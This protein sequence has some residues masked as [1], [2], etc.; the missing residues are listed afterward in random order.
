MGRGSTLEEKDD[1]GRHCCRAGELSKG[2]ATAHQVA[3]I[4]YHNLFSL[5]P[6]SKGLFPSDMH[7]QGSKL[8]QMT[9]LAVYGL[10]SPE[11]LQRFSD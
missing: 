5:D 2:G 4:L 10:K 6:E 9:G 8:M 1:T 7:A 3:E 11:T